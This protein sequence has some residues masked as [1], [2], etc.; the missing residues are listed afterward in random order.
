M[1]RPGSAAWRLPGQVLTS[2]GTALRRWLPLPEP[3]ARSHRVRDYVEVDLGV[4]HAATLE[5]RPQAVE[6][7]AGD[8]QI[9]DHQLGS[10]VDLSLAAVAGRELRL[11]GP[12][13][14]RVDLGQAA[15]EVCPF[16]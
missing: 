2:V 16:A 14:L 3:R 13:D 6:H 7:R 4:G 12:P 10:L 9:G 5:H 8:H 15:V 1:D 11:A